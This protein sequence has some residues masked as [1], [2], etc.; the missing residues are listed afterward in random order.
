[1]RIKQRLSHAWR[2]FKDGFPNDEVFVNEA[3]ESLIGGQ[4]SR[5]DRVFISTPN[6]DSLIMPLYNKIS[7]DVAAVDFRHVRVDQNGRYKET[8]EKSSLNELFSVAANQDQTFRA[9]IQDVVISMID[10]GCVAIVP[11]ETSS[12]PSLNTVYD[13]HS[14]R[15]G[16]ITQWFPQHVELE[17]FNDQMGELDTITLPKKDVII[18]ENPHYAVMNE[19]NSILKRLLEKL[20][21]LDAIDTQSGS[22]KLDLIFQLPYPLK[23]DARKKQAEERKAAVE[24]Q[25]LNSRYGIA[26][27]DATEK[28]TQLN[29]P[30]ENNLMDQIKYLVSLLN[31]QLGMSEAIFNGTA[32]EEEMLNYFTRT[33]EPILNAIIDGMKWKFLTKTA[34]TQRQTIM[35]FRDPF[36]LVPVSQ[37]AEIADKFTRNE[38]MSSN[39]M[40]AIIGMEPSS[41]PKANELR[42]ANIPEAKQEIT[43]PNEEVK[44]DVKKNQV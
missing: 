6:G 10:E 17:L 36:K 8:I 41:D 22:G 18:I 9:F 27:I 2:A 15:V 38:I 39:D 43:K 31:G 35:F 3:Y 5:P 23:S 12:N 21:L 24:D 13:I 44:E 20:H 26:Y 34:R 37:I 28:V 11:V 32:N 30:T 7:L 16:R 42:N 14:L 4:S 33:V 40:R 19:P 1:M 29:R 25:L